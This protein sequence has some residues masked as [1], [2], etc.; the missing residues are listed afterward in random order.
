MLVGIFI[1]VTA[2]IWVIYQRDMRISYDR[3]QEKSSIIST[4]YGDVEYTEGGIGPDVLVIHGGGGGYDQG[5]LLTRTV[6]GEKFRWITPSRFGYLKSSMPEEATYDDQAHAYAMLLDHLNVEKTAVVGFSAGG[7]SALLFA[8]LYPDRVSSLTLIS[9]GAA[10][11]SEQAGEQGA[12][13]GKMLANIMQRDFTY[14]I[15][16]NLFKKQIMQLIGAN[17]DVIATLSPQQIELI[18]Q[19]IDYMNPAALRKSG[20]AFDHYA[21]LPNERIAGIKTPT[22]VV[23]AE[24]DTLQPYQNAVFASSMI[25]GARLLSFEKGGHFVAVIKQSVIRKEVSEHISNPGFV[26]NE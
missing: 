15:S 12:K 9:A 26:S 3:V 19:L 24:D 8:L 2:L 4:P 7:P 5:E 6:L 1:V 16:V 23:H 18:D 13:Q 10:N 11:I 17:K 25:P 21:A 14:W 20:A 22:L